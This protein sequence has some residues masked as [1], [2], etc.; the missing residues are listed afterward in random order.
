MS[1]EWDRLVF[2]FAGRIQDVADVVALDAVTF[3]VHFVQRGIVRIVGRRG[4]TVAVVVVVSS[5]LL[6][7]GVG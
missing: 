5:V 1:F 3:A 7:S 6:G 4:R 2:F